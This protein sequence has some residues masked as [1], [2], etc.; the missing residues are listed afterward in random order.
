MSFKVLGIKLLSP[1]RNAIILFYIDYMI[2]DQRHYVEQ[3]EIVDDE[4][5]F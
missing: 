4:C 1:V 3:K 5:P 2:Y